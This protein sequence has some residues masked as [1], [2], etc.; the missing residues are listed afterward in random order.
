M[1]IAK[2]KQNQTQ[3]FFWSGRTDGIGGQHITAD[4]AKYNGGTTLEMLIE[5]RKIIMPTWNQN[6]QASIKAWEDI[7]SE[8]ATCASGTVT[9]VI[10]KDMRPGNIWE[11]RE[12]PA[13]KNNPN[14]DPKTK[15]STVIFQR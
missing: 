10:G 4:I 5:A 9:G 14:I 15:I 8:Y 2:L 3:H 12:L 13:L 11:N 6:N 7:S 1:K